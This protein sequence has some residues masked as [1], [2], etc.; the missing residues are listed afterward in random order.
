MKQ[1]Q[2]ALDLLDA[3]HGNEPN[4]CH[5]REMSVYECLMCALQ[6]LLPR[7]GPL[8]A[9]Y[10]YELLICTICTVVSGIGKGAQEHPF[11]TYGFEGPAPGC[12]DCVE[13][14]IYSGYDQ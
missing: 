8:E 10:A 14:G 13:G 7:V 4:H 3:L 11:A 2:S 5:T 12:W 6:S 1:P 9:T